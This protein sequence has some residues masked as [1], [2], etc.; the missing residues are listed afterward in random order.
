MADSIFGEIFSARRG[1]LTFQRF[2]GLDKD[3]FAHDPEKLY[4]IAVGTTR[5]AVSDEDMMNLFNA[6]LARRQ[7][8]IDAGILE[9]DDE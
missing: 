4:V 1:R 8:Y 2:Y 6:Y 7:E 3:D 5:Q 9:I